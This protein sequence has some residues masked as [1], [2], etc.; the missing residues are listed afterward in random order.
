[1]RIIAGFNVDGAVE[2]QSA[3]EIKISGDVSRLH[4]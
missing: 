2:M 1:M 4:R 3:P